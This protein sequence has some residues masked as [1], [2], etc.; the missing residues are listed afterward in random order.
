MKRLISLLACTTEMLCTL[1]REDWLVG[2]SHECDYPAS[3]ESLPVVTQAN[4]ISGNSREIHEDLKERQKSGLSLYHVNEERLRELKPDLILTQDQC[5]VCAVTSQDVLKATRAITGMETQVLSIKPFTLN[6]VWNE[7]LRVARAVDATEQAKRNLEKWRER[8]RADTTGEETMMILEWLDPI[9]GCG[10]WS[11]ELV[12][13]AGCREPL[14]EAGSHAPWISLQT[15]ERLQ[16]D[17]IVLAPCGMKLPQVIAEAERLGLKS[18]WAALEAVK[19]GRL[20][21]VDGNAYFSRSGPRL[22][23]SVEILREIRRGKERGEGWTK[24]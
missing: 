14:G 2:R 16:P 17:Y 8:L 13:C 18:Q 22:V 5:E 9:M 23:E 10:Y 19:K 3:I 7:Y 1:G 6:E 24:V 4:V 12:E 11:P 20:F 21:A 15:L